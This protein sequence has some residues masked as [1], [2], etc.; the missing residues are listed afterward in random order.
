[1]VVFYSTYKVNAYDMP[2]GIDV[3]VNNY[4]KSILFDCALLRNETTSAFR[5]LMKVLYLS[6]KFV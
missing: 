5:W 4:E 1:M 2:F 3:G 6:Y